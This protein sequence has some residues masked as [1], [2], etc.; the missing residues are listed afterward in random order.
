MIDKIFGQVITCLA[1]PHFTDK[2]PF[3]DYRNSQ[4]IELFCFSPCLGLIL[5]YIICKWILS[6]T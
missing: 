2:I 1:T 4:F 6:N 5:L 3:S